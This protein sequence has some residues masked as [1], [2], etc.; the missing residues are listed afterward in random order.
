MFGEKIMS[1]HLA[2][3]GQKF[4]R[5]VV[6]LSM[7]LGSVGNALP[8]Q[9]AEPAPTQ[10][11]Q[12]TDTPT[13]TPTP[14]PTATELAAETPLPTIT[15]TPQPTFTPTL[16]A[17][18]APTTTTVITTTMV[19][20]QTSLATPTPIE[21]LPS[22]IKLSISPQRVVAGQPLT[23]AWEIEPGK[24]APDTLAV[25]LPIGATP[26]DFKNFDPQTREL[27]VDVTDSL[28]GKLA[29]QTSADSPS[30]SL[31][32]SAELHQAMGTSQDQVVGTARLSIEQIWQTLVDPGKESRVAAVGGQLQIEM[33]ASA[34]QDLTSEPVSITVR[35]LGPDEQPAARVAG[36]V[37]DLTALTKDSKADI[38][39]FKD[40]LT[41]RLKYD[42]AQLSGKEEDLRMYT[43]EEASQTWKPVSSWVD[44]KTHELIAT[45][46]HF[47]IYGTDYEKWA[48]SRLP[49]LGA[50]A[51]SPF[52]GGSSYSIP[53]S[54][55]PGPGGMQPSLSLGY[56]SQTID[57]STAATT[58]DATYGMGWALNTSAI[59][60]D[61][62]GLDRVDNK[63]DDTFSFSAGG[64]SSQILKGTDQYYHTTDE[65]FWRIQYNSSSDTWTAWDKVGNIYEFGADNQKAV[66]PGFNSNLCAN[67]QY[68]YSPAVYQWLLRRVTNINDVTIVYSYNL[69]NETVEE[70]CTNIKYTTTWT[71]GVYPSEVRYASDH[72]RVLFTLNGGWMGTWLTEV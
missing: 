52:T 34:L 69:V 8:A 17:M 55:P 48:A 16:S 11:V 9:A 65:S 31:A 54:V 27:L 61:W 22:S 62:H 35:M 51:V 64:L 30:S 43:W 12:P 2:T 5:F 67:G 18:T 32:F 25:R 71:T 21:T 20:T 28:S 23:L 42:P 38:H 47:S 24:A 19:A 36:P 10:V 59:V 44:L 57:A 14:T 45:T 50:Y 13:E 3:I 15:P 33:P 72:Y 41:L 53:F 56:S 63:S 7:L 60:R 26:E 40:S 37:F 58:F 39:Q 1:R 6:V 49:T 46:D 70:T 29:L 68:P 66:Y 4:V